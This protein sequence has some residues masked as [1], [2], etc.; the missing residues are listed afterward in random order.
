M[1][2]TISWFDVRFVV[3][4]NPSVVLVLPRLWAHRCCNLYEMMG[5]QL[6]REKNAISFRPFPVSSGRGFFNWFLS[7]ARYIFFSNVV[8]SWSWTSLFPQKNFA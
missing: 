5:S 1:R 3:E 6:C 2:M 4:R 8:W 7:H